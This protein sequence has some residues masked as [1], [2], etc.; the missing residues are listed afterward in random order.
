[1]KPC[2]SYLSPGMRNLA[3]TPTM[4]PMNPK[5]VHHMLSQTY[6][7]ALLSQIKG[8]NSPCRPHVGV[9]CGRRPCKG[10]A[11]RYEYLASPPAIATE[12]GLDRQN[13]VDNGPAE[14]SC[15]SPDS[16]IEAVL[17]GLCFDKHL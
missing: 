7:M 5:D 4:K 9:P 16:R 8:C 14:S 3:I 15:D 6:R 2:G 12:G 10:S 1:M 11:A 17:G 13:K